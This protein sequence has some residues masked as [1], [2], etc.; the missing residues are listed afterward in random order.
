MPPYKKPYPHG[1]KSKTFNFW[2]SHVRI[3]IEHAFGILKGRWKSLCG[4]RLQVY[5]DSGYEYAVKWII[6]CVVLHNMMLDFNDPWSDP[7]EGADSDS[8][9]DEEEAAAIQAQTT[10]A[11]KREL[12]AGIVNL[13]AE[14][15]Q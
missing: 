1:E 5:D 13:W 12:M 4:L 8:D 2:L 14:A 11:G 7:E 15:N 9:S 3:D 10:G 6:S